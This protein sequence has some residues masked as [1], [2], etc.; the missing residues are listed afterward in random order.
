MIVDLLSV[1]DKF[2]LNSLTR[3][4]PTTN[5]AVIITSEGAPVCENGHE[6]EG[7]EHPS[8]TITE[9]HSHSHN[10]VVSFSLL[11]VF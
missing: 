9:T 8:V 7:I 6:M 11:N 3:S 2:H 5:K 1:S 10:H 4:A